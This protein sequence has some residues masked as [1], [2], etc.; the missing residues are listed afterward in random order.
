MSAHR[1]GYTRTEYWANGVVFFC[2]G[3]VF[4]VLL[5]SVA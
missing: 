5:W 1:G 4:G 2:V 3:I